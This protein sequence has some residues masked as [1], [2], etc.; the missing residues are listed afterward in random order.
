MTAPKAKTSHPKTELRVANKKPEWWNSALCGAVNQYSPFGQMVLE[1]GVNT[2]Q[3]V[4]SGFCKGHLEDGNQP[5]S[6]VAFLKAITRKVGATTFFSRGSILGPGE[7]D[8][9]IS[10]PKGAIAIHSG[11]DHRVTIEMMTLDQTQHAQL[12]AIIGE[13]V[14]PSNVRKPIYSIA[15]VNNNLEII[16]VGLAAEELEEGNYTPEVIRDYKFLI[17][18]LQRPVP[19]GRLT[20]I[21]GEPGTGKSF[22]LRG[23]MHEVLDSIFVLIPSHMVQDLTGPELIPTLVKARG[24]TGSEDSI[25]LLLEDADKALVKR[26]NE[27]F[28]AIASLLNASDGILGLTLNLRIVCTTNAVIPD[29]DEALMRPGR[30][31]SKINIT[32]LPPEQCAEIYERITDGEKNQFL[33]PTSLAD[34]YRF[35]NLAIIE[36]EESDTYETEDDD[37]D[38]DEEG[39]DDDDDDDADDDEDDDK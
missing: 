20:L 13:F 26:N 11:L 14:I 3:G 15:R 10:W 38:D 19:T 5:E 23:L 34:V 25:I 17:T 7:Q 37:D 4:Y 16:E 28:G 33:E 8:T 35:A 39:W 32:N 24:L 12:G 29:I 22:L 18:E 9:W 1:H 30:M 2:G 21:H 36:E 6:F 31:S 27:S